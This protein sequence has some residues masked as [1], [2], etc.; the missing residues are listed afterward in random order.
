MRFFFKSFLL[1]YDSRTTVLEISLEIFQIF[2][3]MPSANFSLQLDRFK[4]SMRFK[5]TSTYPK[6][7]ELLGG[8]SKKSITEKH[9]EYEI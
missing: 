2:F 7:S 1:Y 3:I 4:S 8:R 9:T 6:S 5:M